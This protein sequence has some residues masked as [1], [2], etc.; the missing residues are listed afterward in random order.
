MPR[1]CP[2]H[3]SVHEV[4]EAQVCRTPDARAVIFEFKA[5][6]Y[7]EL[8][9]KDNRLTGRLQQEGVC[10]RD[11][12][13]VLMKRSLELVISYLAI[14]IAGAAFAPLDQEWPSERIKALLTQLRGQVEV[15]TQDTPSFNDLSDW[16]GVVV[17]GAGLQELPENL[18]LSVQ[19]DDPVYVMFT[20][21][22]TRNPKGAI[23][24]HRGMVNRLWNIQ[25]RYP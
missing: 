3:Q 16:N 10:P 17:D 25:E 5:L 1:A 20:S 6:M 11:F 2:D 8:N 24:H 21:G 9:V 19:L 22:S 4:F 15:A 13:P 23:K 18:T 14:L 7:Q 12:V